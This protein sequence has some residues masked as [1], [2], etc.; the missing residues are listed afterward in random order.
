[1][2]AGRFEVETILRA[3]R[4]HLARRHVC[5]FATSQDDVPWAASAFYVARDLDIFTCQRKDART[6]A[7][8]LANPRVSFAVDD[9]TTEAWLQALGTVRPA[10][11]EEDAWARQAL[12]RAAPEFTK[13]FSNPEYPVLAVLV[14]EFTFIDRGAE[15]VPRQHLILGPAGWR[16]A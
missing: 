13:H 9:G 10:T 16:F 8:M 12:R 1:M 15:I 7:Q 11:A 6:L 2:A 14:G 4:A 3:A 5:T